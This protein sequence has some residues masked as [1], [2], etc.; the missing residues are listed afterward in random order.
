VQAPLLAVLLVAQA[1][2][3]AFPALPADP[4]WIVVVVF[5]KL[6]V[7]G[8]LFYATVRMWLAARAAEGT[9]AAPRL[10]YLFYASLVARW[11]S[12]SPASRWSARSSPP[13]TCTSW[14]RPS[15]A[16]ASSTSRRSSAASPR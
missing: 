9:A 6:Y 7:I 15:C 16:S 1:L 10:R 4:A 11:R 13:S 8:G 12:A 3:L 2:A 14:R 5:G